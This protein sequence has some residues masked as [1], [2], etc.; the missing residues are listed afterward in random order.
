MDYNN[1]VFRLRSGTFIPAIGLGTWLIDNEK[2]KDVV[3]NA[4]SLGYRH[5]DTAQ[6]YG[7][8]EGIGKALKELNINRSDIYITSKVKAEIKNYKDAKASIDESL[9]KLGVS[10]IDLMLIHC[11]Q[12]WDE[13]GKPYRYE[14]E[15]IEVWKALTEAYQ[16]GKVK[17]I[18]VSN[19][20]IHDLENIMNNSD[21][22]PMVN[23]V[24]CSPLNSPLDLIKYCK[25]HDIIFEAYS[26]LAHGRAAGF[27]KVE[28]LSNKYHKSFAQISLKYV[29]SLDVVIL[30]KASS[31][32]HLKNNLD[33]DFEMTKEDLDLLK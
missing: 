25:D 7:N 4:I 2:V 29:E 28:M 6:A 19:F 23:Q 9:G 17:A 18:G 16:E 31:L 11:P 8:E 5:I 12:P 33:L 24:S 27:E 26:P 21:I 22:K 10:Y 20:N 30:P 14:K 3:K 1:K 32:D 13:L 15:N